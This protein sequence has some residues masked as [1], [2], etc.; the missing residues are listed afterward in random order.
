MLL[1]DFERTNG[2]LRTEYDVFDNEGEYIESFIVDY[3]DPTNTNKIS[4]RLMYEDEN[5]TIR[6][7]RINKAKNILNVSITAKGEKND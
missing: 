4:K 3:L 6:F 5:A 2:E 7:V 1:K